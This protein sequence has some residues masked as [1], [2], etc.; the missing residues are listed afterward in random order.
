MNTAANI[1]VTEDYISRTFFT[2]LAAADTTTTRTLFASRSLR[3]SSTLSCVKFPNCQ[4]NT[5]SPR[6]FYKL[7]PLPV[8]FCNFFWEFLR[9]LVAAPI[10]FVAPM[11]SSGSRVDIA[12]NQTRVARFWINAGKYFCD[13]HEI[14]SSEDFL[15]YC[16]NFGVDGNPQEFFE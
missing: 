11:R 16:K 5:H 10:F 2:Y 1:H 9:E 15:L 8:F 14:N 13:F 12:Q 3:N 4:E 7:I 6:N